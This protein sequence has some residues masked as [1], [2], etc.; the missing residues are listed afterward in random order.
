MSNVG[1]N[2]TIE[3]LTEMFQNAIRRWIEKNPELSANVAKETVNA[4]REYL[5]LT[6]A[7]K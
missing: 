5:A 1:E 7:S 6:G 3:Q 2:P 4:L